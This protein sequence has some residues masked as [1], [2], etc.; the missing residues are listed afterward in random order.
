[1]AGSWRPRTT[2]E[3]EP[4]SALPSPKHLPILQK[5]EIFAKMD[6]QLDLDDKIIAVVD[7]HGPLRRGMRD[8]L[9]AFGAKVLF[10]ASGQDFLQEPPFVHCLVV[11]YYMPGLNGLDL[12]SRLRRRAYSAPIIILTGMINDIPADQLAGLGVTEIVAKSSGGDALL[13]AIG[14]H[15][16]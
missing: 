1:M 2:P 10:Y 9:Q 16:A 6:S 8:L 5:E 11:D 7:D 13:L 14:R 4:F 12:V 3:A 15:A